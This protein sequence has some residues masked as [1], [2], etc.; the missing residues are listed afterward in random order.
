ME[1]RIRQGFEEA[2]YP[3]FGNRSSKPRSLMLAGDVYGLKDDE[4][5]LISNSESD[6]DDEESDTE[7]VEHRSEVEP[8]IIEE[9]GIAPFNRYT[10][11]LSI[12]GIFSASIFDCLN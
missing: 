4:E 5:G 6:Y 7:K 10:N 3:K 1:E 11:F 8:P 2:N 12:L 9:I